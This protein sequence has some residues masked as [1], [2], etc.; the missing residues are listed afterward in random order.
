VTRQQSSRPN[1]ILVQLEAFRAWD[2]GTTNPAI[3]DSPTPFLDRL[4]RSSD[5]AYYSRFFANGIPTVFTFMAIH[6]GLVPHSFYT[7]AQRFTTTGFDAFPKLLRTR[8]YYSLFFTGSDPDWDNQRFWLRQ[9]Y[10]EHHFWP[11]H[12]E[13]DRDTFRAAAERIAQVGQV[14]EPFIATL[15]S[16]TNHIPFRLPEPAFAKERGDTS[17]A[18]LHNTMRYTDDVVREFYER[19]RGERWFDRTVWL[20]TGDHGY[21]LGERGAPIGHDN[22]RH[23]STWVPLIVHGSDSRLPKGVQQRV[24]S[25]IDLAPTITELAGYTGPVAFSG[26]SLLQPT[27]ERHSAVAVRKGNFAYET[28]AFS[29]YYPVSGK[30]SVYEGKDILQ[31]RALTDQMPHVVEEY[32]ERARLL[33]TVTDWAIESDRVAPT[34]K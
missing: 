3:K 11:A 22:L 26:H 30:P 25:H 19:L 14:R 4:A 31:N 16:I 5:S 9:W 27:T 1:I 23:E 33:S 28:Q 10:D 12:K 8:G 15:A 2:M 18:R 13:R 32:R 24:G 7:V 34:T 6:T 29:A 17:R 21:D 20:I